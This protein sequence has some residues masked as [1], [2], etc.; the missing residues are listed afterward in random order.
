MDRSGRVIVGIGVLLLFIPRMGWTQAA[1]TTGTIAG[2]VRDATGAFL[3]GVTVEAAS[4]ALIEKVRTVVTDAQGTYRIVDLRPGTYTVTFTLPGFSAFKREGIEL[5]AGFTAAVNAD[6]TVGAL[7]E[8]VTVTGAS[9][10][11]DVQNVRTQQTFTQELLNTVPTAKSYLGMNALT[12]GATGG[13]GST[14]PV[15]TATSAAA[16]STVSTRWR[17]TGAAPTASIGSRA[18]AT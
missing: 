11:V 7:D 4:P 12:L 6:L 10:V 8:T 18:C 2:S 16:T 17:F 1:T 3:P 5:S 9:P 13:G 14:G 15:A